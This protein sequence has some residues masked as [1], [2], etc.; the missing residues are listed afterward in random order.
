M[1]S[2]EI[3]IKSATIRLLS[4]GIVETIIADYTTLDCENVLKI[5]ETNLEL[6]GGLPYAV[7]V[8]SG[9]FTGITQEAREL[10]ASSEFSQN[11]IAKAL[12]VRSLGHRIVGEFYIRVNKP[13]IKTKIFADRTKAIEW[14]QKKVSNCPN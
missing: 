1:T 9:M 3:K 13:K 14:L 4:P 2:K 11:T 5:K 12:L 6:T 10:S 8:D 7:L